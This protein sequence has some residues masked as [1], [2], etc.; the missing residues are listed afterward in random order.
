MKNFL[1]MV[2]AACGLLLAGCATNV[3]D[4]PAVD[5]ARRMIA[6][7]RAECVIV[8][9]GLVESQRGNGVMPLLNFHDHSP[10]HFAGAI[11]VDK[12]V[13]RAA[14]MIAIHGKAFAVYGEVMSQDALELLGK[15]GIPAG[16]DQLVPQ[17]LN[18]SRTGLCPLE[19]A[20]AGIEDPALA[21][22]ALRRRI[23]QLR[24]AAPKRDRR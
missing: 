10:W 2:F 17:I 18:A 8:K 5:D 7:R 22:A 3:F 6:E 4:N 21:V 1:T 19:Q 20:V 24:A 9:D 11:V 15:Y 13:G 12:V 23:V 16:C 14:A